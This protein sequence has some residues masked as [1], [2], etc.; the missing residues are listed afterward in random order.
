MN[1]EVASRVEEVYKYFLTRHGSNR[2][3][4]GA[5]TQAYF[6]A[7]NGFKLDDIDTS[8]GDLQETV[9]HS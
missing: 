6:M 8:L 4:A 5:L 3:L 9:R 1:K 7:L 2:E